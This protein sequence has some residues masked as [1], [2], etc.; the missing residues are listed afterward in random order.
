MILVVHS[1]S[2]V[3]IHLFREAGLDGPYVCCH[4]F[5]FYQLILIWTEDTC[6]TNFKGQYHIQYSMVAQVSIISSYHLLYQ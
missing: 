1:L 4:E 2:N 3:Y 6:W 5:C